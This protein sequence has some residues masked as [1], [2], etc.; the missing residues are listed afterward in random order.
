[1]PLTLRRTDRKTMAVEA[2]VIK[3]ES[4][5]TLSPAQVERIELPCG[6][7]SIPLAELFDMEGNLSDGHLILE[8]DLTHLHG[9][10]AGMGSGKLTLRGDVGSR[11]AT[12]MTGG[13][14][15]A[16]GSVGPWAGAEMKGGL[17]RISGDA[18]DNLGSALPGSRVGMRDGVILVG[19]SVG[20]EAGLAMRRGLISIQGETGPLLGR[21]MVAG[22]IFAF[23]RLGPLAGL[24]VKRG[25]IASFGGMMELLPTYAP[26]GR[27]R[28]PFLTLYLRQLAAWGIDL[29]E[30]VF[31][32]RFD[33]YNGDLAGLGQGE[34]L[35][36]R[37]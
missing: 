31:S 16:H 7:E 29:P 26:S 20:S 5:Q 15:V 28:P 14:V 6:N 25:T 34:L 22:S 36:W 12:G 21:S 11:L 13:E 24:G 27:S 17:L 35:V 18:G 4:L 8:G 19:G 2:S 23:G 3:P 37:N 30:G 33:R 9:L 32:G 1:M 10:A